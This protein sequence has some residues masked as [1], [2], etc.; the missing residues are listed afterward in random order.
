VN[1]RVVYVAGPIS[2]GDLCHNINQ[3][4]RA[5]KELA[6]AGLAPLVPHWS[7][8]S[9]GALVSAS[10]G[11]VFAFATVG[12]CGL[13]HAEWIELDLAFVERSDALL[14]L[15]GESVGADAEVAHATAKGIPVFTSVEDVIRWAWESGSVVA[16]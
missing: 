11:S 16:S 10:G 14:R 12:G 8:F 7:C 13:P 4:N 3:A 15:P 9:G 5:F 2:R 6:E 1:R